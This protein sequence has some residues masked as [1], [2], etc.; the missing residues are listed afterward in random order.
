MTIEWESGANRIYAIEVSDDLM[1]WE[2][3]DD[4]VTSEGD[5]TTFTDTQI[6]LNSSKRF[7][8]VHE[9]ER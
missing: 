3:L 6:P 5:T 9:M 8:R 4:N 1:L 2:E 7:Y